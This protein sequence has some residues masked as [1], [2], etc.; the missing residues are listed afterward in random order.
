MHGGAFGSRVVLPALKEH[1]ISTLEA[2]IITHANLDHFSCVGDLVGRIP[3]GE[4]VV[5]QS[6]LKDA[7]KHTD[8]ATSECLRMTRLWDIPVRT[9]VAG[10]QENFC[11]LSWEILHP[12]RDSHWNKE[13][14]AS[15][16]LQVTIASQIGICELMRSNGLISIE[17]VRRSDMIFA[18][19][20]GALY[21]LVHVGFQI[22]F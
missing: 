6:F 9:V 11:G 22:L 21:F 12:P 1:G 17:G 3:I 2:I 5:G 20:L 19:T 10:D 18:A 16:V 13:N 14:N 8:G 15:L 4:I 7:L